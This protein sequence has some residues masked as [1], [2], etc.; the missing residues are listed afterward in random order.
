MAPYAIAHLKLG[1]RLKETGYDIEQ[2]ERLQVYLTNSLE[3]AH[4]RDHGQLTFFGTW[5]AE[6]ADRASEVKR[7]LPIMVILGNPPYSGHSA[8]TGEWITDLLRGN[9]SISGAPAQSYFEV[10]GQPL[11]ERNPKWLHDDY[12]KFIRFGQ[13]RIERTGAGVLAF[14]T[15]HNYIDALTFRGMRQSLGMAFD[16][17][18]IMDLH[19][20]AKRVEKAP[21]GSADE[22]VF[23]IQQGV[24]IS[25]LTRHASPS[26]HRVDHAD[27]W[28]SRQEKYRWLSANS[29][30]TTEWRQA[31]AQSPS[32]SFV[33]RDEALSAEYV[34]GWSIV[35]A[36][37]VSVLGFQ[38]HRDAFAIAFDEQTMRERISD[39]RNGQ[40]SDETVRAKYGLRDTRDWSLTAAR[41]AIQADS[42]WESRIE[43]CLYR[44][45]DYR[46]CYFSYAAMDFP[47]RELLDH[48]AGTRTT[49]LL[50]PRQTSTSRWEHAFVSAGVAESCAISSKTKEQNYDFPLTLKDVRLDE[51][52]PLSIVDSGGGRSNFASGFLAALG[53]G[54]STRENGVDRVSVEPRT[55]MSYAYAVL[56]SPTYRERYSDF[57]KSDFPRI[58]LTSDRELFR[59]LCRLGARLVT[60]HLM[61]AADLAPVTTYPVPGD[62]RVEKVRYTEPG[63]GAE[64]GRV[65]INATQYFEGV[66]PEVWEFH[67]GG[68]QVCAK[69]LKDRKGRQ[70]SYADLTHYQY[71]VAALAETI[72]LMREIDEVIEAHAGWPLS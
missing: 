16:S 59:E 62:N 54:E 20:S 57:L 31:A 35:E 12:V 58:P 61:E 21:D 65:W 55:A 28:G 7:E 41:K 64:Q 24:A 49:C 30:M 11:G 50:V 26:E 10:D 45:F 8:N 52:S 9:G 22:N 25:L 5:L 38:T 32:F 29:E 48:V 3:E 2:S 46:W 4:E 33:P 19:G 23:D 72:A 60:L 63:Q 1:L 69:W 44:P 14:V 66:P 67:V 6:E 15:N 39:L 40:L 36:M 42:Q 43:R 56:S 37:P 47:R 71:V 17:I 51:E 68:Y 18:R 27:L 13:W 34:R 70:L 53:S